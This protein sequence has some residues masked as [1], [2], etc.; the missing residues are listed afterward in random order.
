MKLIIDA[1]SFLNQALLRGTDHDQGRVVEFEGKQVQVNSAQYGIDGFWDKV[2]QVLDRFDV[3]PRKVILVWD[4][5]SAKAMR[6]NWLPTYKQGRD[7]C[8]EVSAELNKAREQVSKM[9]YHLGIM[10]VQQ[11]AREADDVIGYLCKYLR[12]ER[13]TVCSSDG[14][15]AVL[16]DEN[17]DVW[18]GEYLN[19]N[20]FGGFPH[21]FITLYKA[22][23]GDTSDKI[24]GAKGFGDAAFVELVRLFGLEG[25]AEVENLIKAGKLDE[26]KDNVADLKAIQKILDNKDMVATSWRCASLHV[27]D[28]NT[29]SKPMDVKPGMIGQWHE[30]ADELKVPELRRFYGSKTL[31]TADNYEAIYKRFSGAVHAS[32]F[33]ALDIETSSSEESDDWIRAVNAMSE[34]SKGGKID[35][36]GHELTGMGLTFGENTQHTIYMSVDHKDTNNI[37]VDQCRAMVE[38]IPHKKMHTVI[39]NRQFE[40]SVLY[41]TWGD[42]WLDNGWHGMIP[43]AIDTV[44]GGSYTDENLPKGLKDRSKL[45]LGYE[46]ATY[47]ETTSKSG[48]VGTLKGGEKVK[49]YKHCLR[50]GLMVESIDQDTGEVGYVQAEPAVYEMWE[51]RQYKMNELTGNEVLNYGA[52]DTICTAALHTYYSFTMELENTWD[53]Y[54]EVE[55][56][57]EYLTSLAFV[58]GIPVSMSSLRNME[59]QDNA[60]YAKAWSVLKDYLMRNGWEGTV[61][62][63]ATEINVDSIRDALNVCCDNEEPFTTRK[64]KIEA[65]LEDVQAYLG[66]DDDT[67]FFMEMLRSKDVDRLNA[68]V[69]MCFTG[70]PKLNFSSPKQLQNLFYRVIGVTPRIINKMTAKQRDDDDMR[71]AFKKFRQAKEGKVVEYTA[72]EWESLISK[73]STDDDAVDSALALDNLTEDQKQVLIAYQTVKSITTLRSLFYKP[74]K[75]LVH[76]RDQRVHPSLNQCEAATRRYSSSS[77]NVQQLPKGAGGFREII[78]PPLPDWVVF[79][80]DLSGQELRLQAE[81][82]GDE[83]MT[84]CYVGDNKRDMHHLTAV[85]AAPVIWGEHISYATLVEMLESHEDPVKKKAKALRGDA[86]TVNFA[87]AYGAMAPKVALTLKTTEEVAQAFIDAKDKAFP[88]LGIWKDT[89]EAKANERGYALTMM[90]ARRHLAKI[91]NAEDKW[92]RM[93]GER[94]ASNFEIQGSGAE[95]LKLALASMWR[96]G[97]FTGKYRA[98]FYA[99]IHDE[100]VGT[101]HRDDLIPLLRDLHPCMTQ[102]YSTMKIPLESSISIGL[103]F[104]TQIE[105]G[106]TVDELK[107]KEALTEL[108]GS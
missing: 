74:Y 99:P 40:F 12:T 85:T 61:C 97:I 45:H 81:L 106:T 64:R 2:K 96:K 15:L 24:P 47:L 50:E 59:E 105:L 37:T 18:N 20:P 84:S 100:V 72:Q 5:A 39:Q 46:Q 70:E 34:K 53:I 63:V 35:V 21:R 8:P 92:E 79:S 38:L 76:W 13:N 33:V 29:M 77:P 108:F 31:V 22:L 67:G 9:A 95:M 25:L 60:K 49:E 58:Q 90:G 41:R 32:P 103:T 80:L 43:N 91:L 36:L 82:S 78:K 86:K 101:C 107:I 68:Y 62:P 56:L 11:K 75:G 83:A 7:K 65:V 93:K 14:D 16:V 87:T 3:A 94:Q 71:N 57:P 52:D 27:D 88:G 51:T 23:V 102:Q 54:L 98:R 4:G 17:T 26:L 10:V 42:K 69:K 1:N 48:P 66:D 104:G 73:A 30:L 89:A 6:Q 19:K 44:I 55:T 28:V